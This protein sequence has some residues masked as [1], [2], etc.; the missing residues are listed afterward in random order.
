MS[1]ANKETYAFQPP[2]RVFRLGERTDFASRRVTVTSHNNRWWA[3][4]QSRFDDLCA[5]EPGWDGYRG[6]PVNFTVATFAANLLERIFVPGLAEPALVP[7]SDGTL[8]IEWHRNGYDVEI[9]VLA[10]NKVVALRYDHRSDSEE[11][12]ELENDFS[13]LLS[14]V[15]ELAAARENAE[16]ASL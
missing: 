1:L 3:N 15:N 14:W 16:A 5:L 11:V 2:A 10:P 6:K 8:Q 4:L 7:G 9:D 13:I 12:S